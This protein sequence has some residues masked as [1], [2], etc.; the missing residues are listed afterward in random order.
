MVSKT[1]STIQ[2]S[3]FMST[4]MLQ[5]NNNVLQLS[6]PSIQC[7][8][9]LVSPP[10]VR[11]EQLSLSHGNKLIFKEV[12]LSIEPGSVTA[13]IGPS[14]CG[15]TS[16]LSCL[17]RLTEMNPQSKVKGSIRLGGID[18]KKINVIELRRRVGM[19]FQ[20]PIPF[21]FSIQDNIEFPLREHGI[22]ERDRITSILEEVLQNVGLWDEVKNRLHHSALSLSGGQQQR[23]CLARAIALN[24][25][26]LLMDE[27]CSALDPISCDVIEEL[28]S[29]LRGR[30]T[31]LIV[32]HNLAQ[33]RR[34]A[35]DA[36]LLWNID[37]VG[38]LIESGS[39]EQMFESPY[40][41]LTKAYIS[42]KRC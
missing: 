3:G 6:S 41:P 13:L 29:N 34:V 8:S 40:H 11:T 19:L 16:F 35:D 20:K 17:N 30:Y 9:S 12:C 14:G 4:A 5:K 26:V 36:A 42:G 21:P 37:G 39:V 15:K 23:L 28:I 33:A 1:L 18:T 22:K 24:P 7:N 27:P 38:H 2:N 32:T 10:S 31:I 25:D